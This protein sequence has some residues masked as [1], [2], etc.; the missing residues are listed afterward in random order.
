M[1]FFLASTLCSALWPSGSSSAATLRVNRL[2]RVSVHVSVYCSSSERC[3]PLYMSG[4]WQERNHA[5]ELLGVM[6]GASAGTLKAAFRMRALEFH[7]DRNQQ[8]PAAA[9]EKF[10]EI[11]QAYE[12]LDN[13]QRK[14]SGFGTGSSWVSQRARQSQPGVDRS[15]QARKHSNWAPPPSTWTP[16]PAAPPPQPSA[17]WDWKRAQPSSPAQGVPQQPWQ[18]TATPPPATP[19]QQPPQR[20]WNRRPPATHAPQP[21]PQSWTRQ[22][23]TPPAPQ[24]IWN[25]QPPAAPAP[26]PS[27]ESGWS[28]TRASQQPSGFWRR[29]DQ[30]TPDPPVQAAPPGRI[31]PEARVVEA[32]AEPARAPSAPRDFASFNIPGKQ[33]FKPHAGPQPL[34]KKVTVP[35]GW[36]GGG[37]QAT[38]TMMVSAPDG[39]V[40][41]VE[42][43]PTLR[44]GEQFEVEFP[45][46]PNPALPWSFR[47]LLKQVRDM[48]SMTPPQLQGYKAPQPWARTQQP[49]TKSSLWEA[50]QVSREDRGRRW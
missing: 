11:R 47:K 50:Y 35:N 17:R 24:R 43:P 42:V 41:K 15:E 25:R 7:P 37:G 29:G 26:Q 28:F 31:W 21:R 10:T 23:P 30:P 1:I 33:W 9:Q 19:V 36:W 32:T 20:V 6:P 16:P 40:F 14:R 34:R 4:T 5:H 38:R 39:R 12:L 49:A 22:P 13:N 46:A 48:S 45:E 3:G 18:Q 27:P 44:T 2:T 8:D